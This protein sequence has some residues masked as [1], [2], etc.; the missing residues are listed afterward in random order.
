[1]GVFAVIMP[2]GVGLVFNNYRIFGKTK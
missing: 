1:M 2:F